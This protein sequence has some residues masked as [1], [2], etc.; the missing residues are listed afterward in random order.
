MRRRTMVALGLGG[1]AAAVTAAAS[2]RHWI[3]YGGETS[4]RPDED[5]IFTVFAPGGRGSFFVNGPIGRVMAKMMP[6]VER[7]VYEAVAQ[8]LELK[9]DDELLDI[10][11][12][13]GAFLATKAAKVQRVVGIDPSPVM[14]HEAQRRLA[15]RIAAGTGRLISGSAA[16]LPFDDGEFSAAT[17][18]FAPAKPTEVFRVL[19]P[20]GRFVMADPDPKMSD[21]EP[22]TSWGAPRWGEADYRQMLENAGF[23]DL[24]VRF[25]GTALLI[26]G[27]KPTASLPNAFVQDDERERVAAAMS[28]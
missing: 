14:L 23:A 27:Q 8:M 15:D 2:V 20:G 1:T 12:G 13:P 17:A 6:I 11:S 18:I 7:G 19:R 3:W 25:V 26:A 22:S 21:K 9:P 24:T 28:A 16:A 10:G 4:T 5:A